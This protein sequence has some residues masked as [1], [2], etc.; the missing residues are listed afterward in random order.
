MAHPDVQ[1]AISLALIAQGTSEIQRM[2]VGSALVERH[3]ITDA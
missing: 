3:R 2:P 1:C